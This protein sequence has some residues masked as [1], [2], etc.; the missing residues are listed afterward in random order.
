MNLIIC[1]GLYHGLGPKLSNSPSEYRILEIVQF[2]KVSPNETNN[3]FIWV[4]SSFSFLLFSF[5]RFQTKLVV[6]KKHPLRGPYGNLIDSNFLQCTL[7]RQIILFIE[8]KVTYFACKGHLILQDPRE[9]WQLWK[10][11]SSIR[12]YSYELS[13]KYTSYQKQI[14]WLKQ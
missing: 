2:R 12:L 7:V 3:L 14:F 1:N 5:K 10:K 6:S 9:S 13:N 4:L 11:V 8:L